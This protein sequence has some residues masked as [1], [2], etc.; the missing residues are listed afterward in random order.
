MLNGRRIRTKEKEK[1]VRKGAAN[2]N[3]LYFCSMI[4]R[5]KDAPK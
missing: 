1:K 5:E 4:A 2:V 3:G